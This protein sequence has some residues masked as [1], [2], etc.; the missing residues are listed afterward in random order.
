MDGPPEKSS[1]HVAEPLKTVGHPGERLAATSLGRDEGNF[2]GWMAEVRTIAVEGYR[3]VLEDGKDFCSSEREAEYSRHGDEFP[4]PE[5]YI[6]RIL[7]E[8]GKPVP[9]RAH[10]DGGP[11]E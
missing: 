8:E 7:D 6:P 10:I 2:E 1:L 9:D 5:M 4:I 11:C 3:L